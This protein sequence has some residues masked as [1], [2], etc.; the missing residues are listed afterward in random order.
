MIILLDNVDS[1][2]DDEDVL[3]DFPKK[4]KK[5]KKYSV[6]KSPNPIS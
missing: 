3:G 1:F 5:S 4:R 2:S 6:L